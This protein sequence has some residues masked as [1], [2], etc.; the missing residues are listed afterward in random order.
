MVCVRPEATAAAC[1]RR[2][3]KVKR[4]TR[5]EIRSILEATAAVV[6]KAAAGVRRRLEETV[7]LALLASEQTEVR[8]VVEEG[9]AAR[10]VDFRT[11]E[12]T[13][14]VTKKVVVVVVDP[15]TMQ[16]VKAEHLAALVGR[17]GLTETQS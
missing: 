6:Q 12:R 4:Q 14:L 13:E 15:T 9:E 7:Q 11:A 17:G 2:T 3:I 10:V 1:T 16:V 8:R 5:L